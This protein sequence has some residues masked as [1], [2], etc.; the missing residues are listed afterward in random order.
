MNNSNI[1]LFNYIFSANF[2][3]EITDNG[4]WMKF[5]ELCKNLK[6]DY[7][8]FVISYGEYLNTS[9][10][11]EVKSLDG[12]G[13]TGGFITFNLIGEKEFYKFKCNQIKNLINDFGSNAFKHMN[14]L[15]ENMNNKSAREVLENAKDNGLISYNSK[16]FMYASNDIAYISFDDIKISFVEKHLVNESNLKTVVYNNYGTQINQNGTTNNATITIT[17]DDDFFKLVLE[18]IDALEIETK[19][20]GID[21]NEI[22]LLKEAVNKKDKKSLLT[23]LSELATVGSFIA[24]M[25]LMTFQGI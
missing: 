17:N 1:N 19:Q 6:K 11:T 15:F 13:W 23:K 8:D 16:I 25:V 4:R 18:K 2:D 9:L 10:A 5:K 20:L 14:N 3:D 24:Q 21:K 22:E 12:A 7:H